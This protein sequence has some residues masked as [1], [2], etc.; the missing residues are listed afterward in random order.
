VV[1]EIHGKIALANRRLQGVLQSPKACSINDP[2]CEAC[3]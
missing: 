3:Q 2:D 1:P